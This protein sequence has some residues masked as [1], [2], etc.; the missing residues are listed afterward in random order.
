MDMFV[1]V[2]L[3]ALVSGLLAV[4]AGTV[5]WPVPSGGPAPEHDDR[6]RELWPAG[7]PHEAPDRPF[8]V[9]EARQA[10]RRH[11]PCNVDRCARKS[12]ATK[13]LAAAGY[14]ELEWA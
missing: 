9:I 2:G 1:L 14:S 5:W 6:V 13:A 10:L 11:R 4:I 7:W 12:A 8:T 3:L